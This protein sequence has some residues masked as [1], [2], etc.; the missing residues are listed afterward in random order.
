MIINLSPRH[1]T[2]LNQGL[3][4]LASFGV[5]RQKTLRTRLDK[6]EAQREGE[7]ENEYEE[8]KEKKKKKSKKTKKKKW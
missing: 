5:G 2:T 4:S 8:E 1:V 3:S 6:G 7:D